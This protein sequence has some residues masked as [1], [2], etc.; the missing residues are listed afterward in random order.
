MVDAQDGAVTCVKCGSR[1]EMACTTPP[2]CGDP[3]DPSK[4]N[5]VVDS[6]NFCR[7]GVIGQPCCLTEPPKCDSARARC[8]LAKATAGIPGAPAGTTEESS[9][10]YCEH[11]GSLNQLT[12]EAGGF[13]DPAPTGC[14]GCTYPRNGLCGLCGGPN[15]HHCFAKTADEPNGC[16]DSDY[17]GGECVA[18]AQL[19]GENCACKSGYTKSGR[20]CVACGGENQPCCNNGINSAC[21][22]SELVCSGGTCTSEK[23]CG[24]PRSSWGEK[25]WNRYVSSMNEYCNGNLNP[26]SGDCPGYSSG[27]PCQKSLCYA[28]CGGSSEFDDLPTGTVYCDM[29]ARPIQVD[30]AACCTSCCS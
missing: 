7:C 27:T 24:I 26:S 28:G 19:S 4:Q 10:F 3:E 14:F 23:M 9:K 29:S 22:N 6:L 15:E 30:T 1:N 8:D 20:T 18:H 12:C 5:Y 25:C 16:Y 21:D 11:C 17:P 2:Q 13:S